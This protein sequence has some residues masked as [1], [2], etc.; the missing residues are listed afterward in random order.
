MVLVGIR[1]DVLITISFSLVAKKNAK[2]CNEELM[3]GF[4]RGGI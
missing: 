3:L 1:K 4:E 2:L